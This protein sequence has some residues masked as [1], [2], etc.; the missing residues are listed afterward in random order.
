MNFIYINSDS[1][2]RDNLGCCGN[3][4]IRFDWRRR[5]A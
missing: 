5:L 1:F 4:H 3:K 2:R